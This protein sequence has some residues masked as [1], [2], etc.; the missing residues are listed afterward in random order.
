VDVEVLEGSGV[1]GDDP[2]GVWAVVGDFEV[3]EGEARGCETGGEGA[4]CEGERGERRE[5][6]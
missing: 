1:W 5:R 4:C 2:G 3:L 6:G